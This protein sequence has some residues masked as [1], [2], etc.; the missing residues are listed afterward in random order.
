MLD[1]SIL[2]LEEE[3]TLRVWNLLTERNLPVPDINELK[4]LLCLSSLGND[5]CGGLSKI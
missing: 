2:R 3:L 5:R 1:Y 4:Q